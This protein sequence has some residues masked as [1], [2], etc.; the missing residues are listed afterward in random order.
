[1][2]GIKVCEA[3]SAHY[4]LHML[5]RSDDA[6]N[7]IIADYDI[8]NSP[9]R[10]VRRAHEQNIL[11][12]HHQD[13][14][15]IELVGTLSFS[16][17]D[18]VS[19]QIAAKPR[20]QLVIFDLRRVTA[21][22][23]AGTRLLAEE[24]PRA[25]GLPRHRDPVRHPAVVAGMEDDRGMD[26]RASATSATTICSMPRSNGRKTRWSIATAARSISSRRPNSPNSRCWRG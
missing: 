25:R 12:A 7:S 21:M 14:R 9:S 4:D 15:V 23:R 20:P 24:F 3:L 1:V 17:V 5:N 16:N 26:G 2:R 18:Y 8:G 19:R 6:R 11:A 22:T 10:R 13:V